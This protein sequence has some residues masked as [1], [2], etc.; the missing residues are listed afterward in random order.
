MMIFL[1][2]SEAHSYDDG[3]G[4]KASSKFKFPRVLLTG[5]DF[6][7][8]RDLLPGS[9]KIFLAE[10]IPFPVGSGG[11]AEFFLEFL[12]EMAQIFKSAGVRDF[13]ERHFCFEKDFR[14]SHPEIE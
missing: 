9:L 13:L 3:F 8:E 6:L 7:S 2:R 11:F 12:A 14:M 1:Q 10:E 5:T 4:G